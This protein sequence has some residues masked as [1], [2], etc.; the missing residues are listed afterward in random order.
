MA[1]LTRDKATRIVREG[2][3]NRR[4]FMT[5]SFRG[6]LVVVFFVFLLIAV[7]FH[8]VGLVVPC[9]Y[10]AMSL[11]T[12]IVYASDKNAAQNNGWRTSERTLHLLEVVCGWP[13]ALL[14]QGW[15]RHKSA[16]TSYGAVFWLMV[17]V[18]FVALLWLMDKRAI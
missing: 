4:P 3:R 17:A 1:K 7:L 15:L 5:L 14:A 8:K 11:V 10:A 18:N 13:G 16:K 2:V 6:A 9:F 12:F